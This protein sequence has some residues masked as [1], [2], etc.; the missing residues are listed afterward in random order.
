MGRGKGRLGGVG[1]GKGGGMRRERTTP[2]I[3]T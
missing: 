1:G 3:K 2:S